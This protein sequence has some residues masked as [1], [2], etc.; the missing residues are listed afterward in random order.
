MAS[1]NKQQGS[2]S[3]TAITDDSIN[4]QATISQS[5]SRVGILRSKTTSP[6]SK[7]TSNFIHLTMWETWHNLPI[8]LRSHR[9]M[10]LL[11]LISVIGFVTSFLFPSSLPIQLLLGCIVYGM[12]D[13][14][15]SGQTQQSYVKYHKSQPIEQES[16]PDDSLIRT[17]RVR[18]AE[19]TKFHRLPKPM[20]RQQKAAYCRNRFYYHRD[21]NGHDN[22]NNQTEQLLQ[23]RNS[24]IPSS[25]S[26]AIE[27]DRKQGTLA[28]GSLESSA[29][30]LLPWSNRQNGKSTLSECQHSEPALE[31][32]NEFI[33]N[34]NQYKPCPNIHQLSSSSKKLIGSDSAIARIREMAHALPLR[35]RNGRAWS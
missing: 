19:G 26:T 24:W 9:N 29:G 15:E 21:A 14:L 11:I 25:S 32:E 8:Q 27:Y 1:E 13:Y 7:I 28:L 10:E 35:E 30:M 17:K 6:S 4:H 33:D 22:G 20:T 5:T 34:E 12:L 3:V 23:M 18:F 31:N 2:S 16:C